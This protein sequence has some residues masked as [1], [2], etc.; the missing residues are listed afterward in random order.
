LGLTLY[1]IWNAD[2][3]NHEVKAAFLIFMF[4]RVLFFLW[5]VAFFYLQA[6]FCALMVM[7]MVIALM[8]CTLVQTLW[9]TVSS[10]LFLVPYLIVMLIFCCANL[11]I[12]WMTPGLPLWGIWGNSIA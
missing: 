4:V 9:S 1:T 2:L 11:M 12:F 10:A 7:L 3:S 6:V 5:F 8:L